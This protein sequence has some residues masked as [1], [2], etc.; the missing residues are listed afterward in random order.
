MMITDN[1]KNIYLSKNKEAAEPQTGGIAPDNVLLDYILTVRETTPFGGRE[2]INYESCS[3]CR[4]MG[5]INR[6][7]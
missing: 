6:K 5:E 2:Y 1:G 4:G 3:R 7:F